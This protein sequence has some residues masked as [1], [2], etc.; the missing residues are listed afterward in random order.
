MQTPLWSFDELMQSV[1]DGR[2]GCSGKALVMYSS[3]RGAMVND[4][5]GM[6]VPVDDHLVHRG[7]GVF[8]TL[9]FEGGGIYNLQAHLKRLQTSAAAIGLELPLSLPDLEQILADC[10]AVAARPR[11]LAR[12]LLGRGPGGFSVDP[13]ESP[14]ASLYIMVYEGSPPFMEKHPEG[15]RA[16]LSRIPP[17]PGGLACI[18]TCNYLPNALMKA[19]ANAAGVHFALGVDGEGYLT[20][21]AT[22]NVA[23]VDK[24]GSLILLPPVQHLPGTTLARVAELAASAGRKV[25]TRRLR[26]SELFDLAEVL[27]VGTTAYVTPLVELDGR[28]VPAGPVA[29]EL[30]ALLREDIRSGGRRG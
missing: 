2:E 27:I 8:E 16:V 20:E 25:V 19:E 23:G 14:R 18:K 1:S 29:G 24:D 15:A 5:R 3:L 9:L 7:D 30:D 22:E 11:A 21:S 12:L 17:K 28:P 6:W 10:F 26:P 4:L 13:A